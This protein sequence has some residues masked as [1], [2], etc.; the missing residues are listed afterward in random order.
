M[1]KYKARASARC[2]R[3]WV[4]MCCRLSQGLRLR[5]VVPGSSICLLP[6]VAQVWQI[7]QDSV[8]VGGG[9][10]AR[11]RCQ[12]ERERGNLLLRSL[13]SFYLPP[14]NLLYLAGLSLMIINICMQMEE[15][16]RERGQ[17]QERERETLPALCGSPYRKRKWSRV[18]RLLRPKDNW[19]CH[20][21]CPASR[22]RAGSVLV[23]QA[24][25]CDD[26]IC[27]RERERE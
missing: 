22:R 26:C 21:R 19:I 27:N 12:R 6:A 8:G 16:E 5:V 24:L 15:G 18:H 11:V 7:G 17:G 2:Q 1:C 20:L 13:P 10:G 23:D 9:E 25:V 3:Q 4:K 14:S